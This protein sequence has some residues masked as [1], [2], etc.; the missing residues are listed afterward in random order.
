MSCQIGTLTSPIIDLAKKIS[1]KKSNTKPR[2]LTKRQKAEALQKK[3]EREEKWQ[4]EYNDIVLRRIAK[5]RFQAERSAKLNRSLYPDLFAAIDTDN[6]K[7]RFKDLTSDDWSIYYEARAE[8]KEFIFYI[9]RCFGMKRK[10]GKHYHF[11]GYDWYMRHRHRHL[12]LC[13][14]EYDISLS[15]IDIKALF[16][17]DLIHCSGSERRRLRMALATPKWSNK[18]EIKKIYDKRDLWNKKAGYSKYHVDHELPIAGELV[19]GLHVP[20]NLRV[21]DGIEN[22]KK[23]NTYVLDA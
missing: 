19:C 16:S 23:K 17:D 12:D 9:T 13:D 7:Q 14:L 11:E 3:K 21:I 22:I 4:Q 8:F 20:D 18:D 6:F 1:K 10:Y 2:K 15:T 5:T